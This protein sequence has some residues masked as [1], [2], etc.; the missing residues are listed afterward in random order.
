MKIH[1]CRGVGD[2]RLRPASNH[3]AMHPVLYFFVVH[4]S[5]VVRVLSSR[6]FDRREKSFLICFIATLSYAAQT[7]ISDGISKTSLRPRRTACKFSCTIFSPRLPKNFRSD[8]STAA[9][10][11]ASLK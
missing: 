2:R 3:A 9:S 7:I 10:M 6:H 4:T 11:S 8:F 5:F 1:D